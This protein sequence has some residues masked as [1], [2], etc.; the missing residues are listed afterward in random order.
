MLIPLI[1]RSKINGMSIHSLFY[2][3]AEGGE[4]LLRQ[5]P[6][7]KPLPSAV[8]RSPAHL[9]RVEVI[10]AR[11]LRQPHGGPQVRRARALESSRT[12]KTDWPDLLKHPPFKRKTGETA[13][14][15]AAKVGSRQKQVKKIE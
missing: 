14:K 15:T 13:P 12:G 1:L 8:W 6:P 11:L 5:A 10:A 7:K 9:P 2:F 3:A 4:Y